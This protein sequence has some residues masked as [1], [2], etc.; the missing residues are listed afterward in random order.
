MFCCVES[1]DKSL[2]SFFVT[3]VPPLQ[4]LW[5]LMT[6]PITETTGTDCLLVVDASEADISALTSMLG[7]VGFEI[8]PALNGAEAIQ[9]LGLRRPDLILLDLHL[10]DMDGFELCRRMQ[11]NS[12]WANIPIIFLS[13]SE[14]KNLVARALESGGVDYITKP[15]HKQELLSRVR[16]QLMLKT[17]RDYARRLAQDKDEML[18]MISHHLQNH[19]VGMHMSAQFLLERTEAKTDPKLKLMAENIRASSG[20]MRAFLKTFFANAAADHGLNLKLEVINLT[21]AVIRSLHQYEDPAKAKQLV[22]RACLPGEPMHRARGRRGLEPGARQPHFQRGQIF[23]SRQG[24]SHHRAG[25]GRQRGI[26]GPGS[27]SRLYRGG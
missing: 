3:R 24:D 16:T 9:M 21:D 11:E 17:S 15:F 14:D 19:L 13:A 27:R 7:K 23:S 5:N 6:V 26:P 4:P 8:L 10:P 20:Q 1:Y 18:G 2:A 25:G 12:E 22:L